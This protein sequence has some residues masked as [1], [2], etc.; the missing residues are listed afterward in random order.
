MIRLALDSLDDETLQEH[1]TDW[2][3]TARSGLL[4]VAALAGLVVPD[5][6]RPAESSTIWHGLTAEMQMARR[7]IEGQ[8]YGMVGLHM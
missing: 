4:Q 8:S 3:D 6:V 5:D 7:S 2:A 1:I